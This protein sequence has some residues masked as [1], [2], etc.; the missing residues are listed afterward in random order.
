MV[1]LTDRK[2]KFTNFLDESSL[3][4]TENY[5]T[6][7]LI[8][9]KQSLLTKNETKLKLRMRSNYS[10]YIFIY[11]ATAYTIS[12]EGAGN[13]TVDDITDTAWTRI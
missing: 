13:L 8:S 7:I 4:L 12:I 3:Y 9:G 2:G 11:P 5:H 1:S 6:Y 10:A